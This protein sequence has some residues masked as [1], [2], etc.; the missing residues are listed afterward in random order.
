MLHK[1]F[2]LLIGLLIGS[3]GWLPYVFLALLWPFYWSYFT[4]NPNANLP[5]PLKLVEVL[6]ALW[7]FFLIGPCLLA[8]YFFRAHPRRP[9]L[10]S[11]ILI[12][13]ALVI[14]AVFFRLLPSPSYVL[15]NLLGF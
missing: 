11:G 12:M 15:D 4:A 13:L 1:T 5:W 9:L 2:S 6:F 14:L 3:L 10:A 8:L 7:P